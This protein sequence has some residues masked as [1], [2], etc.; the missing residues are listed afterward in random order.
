MSVMHKNE[1]PDGSYPEFRALGKG[2]I[3]ENPL[4][5][6]GSCRLKEGRSWMGEDQR[7]GKG[8]IQDERREGGNGHFDTTSSAGGHLIL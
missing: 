5:E 1:H 3:K 8:D 7:G 6:A 4:E 2:T